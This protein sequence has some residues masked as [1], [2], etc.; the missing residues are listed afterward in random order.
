MI[1]TEVYKNIN[2]IDNISSYHLE[3]AM[4]KSDDLMKKVLRVKSDHG[5]EFGIRLSDNNVCLENGSTFKLSDHELLVL[6]T[7]SDKMLVI[8][9]LTI[10]KM[11]ELCHVLGNLHKPIQVKEGKVLVL[12]DGVI[13]KMLDD[14]DFEYTIEDR[15]LDGPLRYVDLSNEK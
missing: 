2:D 14:R 6:N 4:I 1:L 3:I 8:I 5:N 13:Q 15:Q 10:D 12:M 9:P 11:G 7:I